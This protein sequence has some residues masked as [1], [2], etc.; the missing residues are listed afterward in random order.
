MTIL[1]LG[2]GGRT[3]QIL[4][5]NLSLHRYHLL[6]LHPGEIDFT[7]ITSL[8]QIPAHPHFI[9]ADII[10]NCAAMSSIEE[11][12]STP[13]KAHI[14]NAM[15][16]EAVAAYCAR[17]NKQ[18]FHLSTDY[19][20]DG[21]AKGLKEESHKCRPINIYG[22]SKWEAEQRIQT[23]NP[24]AI[25]LRVSWIFGNAERKSF[26]ENVLTQALSQKPLQFIH[27]KYS[28]P[29][30]TNTISNAIIGFITQKNHSGVYHLCDSGE[31]VSWYQ[32][33]QEIIELALELHILQKRPVLTPVSLKDISFFKEARPIHTAMNNKKYSQLLGIKPLSWQESLR[34][35]FPFSDFSNS[36]F[37]PITLK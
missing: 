12:F 13:D 10:I 24:K 9:D 29:T 8:E 31:P 1:I 7:Q 26:A 2:A 27:D 4:F 21:R 35:H 23:V 37:L 20:L 3:G 28:L 30:A 6:S 19:V 17:E 25:I 14:I 33:A 5:K 36:S 15:M 22:E 34:Q 32:Y 16:P 18:F 11:C